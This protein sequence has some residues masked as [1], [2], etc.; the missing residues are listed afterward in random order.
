M[1]IVK[2]GFDLAGQPEQGAAED[3]EPAEDAIPVG[4]GPQAA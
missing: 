3:D 2:G 1:E 4:A